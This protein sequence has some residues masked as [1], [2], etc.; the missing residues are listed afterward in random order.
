MNNQKGEIIA[1]LI[2]LFAIV[3]ILGLPLVFDY[4]DGMPEQKSKKKIK[5]SEA[6][7][8]WFQ[9]LFIS[10]MAGIIIYL[11]KD[12]IDPLFFSGLLATLGLFILGGI[13][14]TIIRFLLDQLKIWRIITGEFW[15]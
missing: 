13:L 15:R 9:V 3:I 14:I 11:V 2:M 8:R 1:G 7:I 4:A 12:V 5:M 6:T 10:L